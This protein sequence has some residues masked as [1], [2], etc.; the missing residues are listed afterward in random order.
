MI[1]ILLASYNGERYIIDQ[2]ESLINQT[3]QDFKVYISDDCSTDSTYSILEDYAKRHADKIV[4]ARNK[5]NA[6][7]AKYNFI[8]M[9][10][11]HKDDYIMLC[12]QDDVWLPDKI[13]K[14]LFRMKDMEKVYG[15]DAP[16]LVH[17]D[18]CVVDEEL[19]VINPSCKEAMN[20][21]FDKTRM[22]NLLIQNM[23]AGCTCMYNRALAEFIEDKSPEYMVM[24]DWWLT[25][26][27]GAFG[28][29]GHINNQTILYRQ[30]GN[31]EIGAKDVRTLRYKIKKLLAYK[32]IKDAVAGTYLQAGS[33][34]HYYKNRLSF[35]QIELLTEYC[36]IPHK[37]KL[38]KWKTIFRL[39]T[40]KN[41]L[42]RNIAYLLFI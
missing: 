7:G 2:L 13:E 16:L 20:A 27:A 39:K 15:K 3:Y 9:M 17:T 34:L 26:V 29:I 11:M 41:G 28:K 35:D 4:I 22:N 21:D 19:N 31:N 24:H 42:S 36:K 33:F 1:S 18:L 25:L 10:F 6:G 40:F 8:Q 14:T 5:T 32:E 37:N 12:D 38:R 23:I 30:H